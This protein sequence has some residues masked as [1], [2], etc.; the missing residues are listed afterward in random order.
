MTPKKRNTVFALLI[1]AAVLI[2]TIAGGNIG[3]NLD[4]GEDALRLRAAGNDWTIPYSEIASLELQDLPD[5]GH[6]VQGS[7]KRSL[8]CGTWENDTWG[9]YTLCIVPKVETCIVITMSDGNHYV[10][11]Y[12]NNESTE[13]FHNMFATLLQS[14]FPC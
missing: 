5:L 12:E 4:F 13:E 9:E 2:Y 10:I 6:R 3:T 7:E 1:L 14:K 8:Y 11:N